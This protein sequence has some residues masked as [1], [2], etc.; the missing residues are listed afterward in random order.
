MISLSYHAL[1]AEDIL[2]KSR[3]HVNIEGIKLDNQPGTLSDSRLGPRTED[4]TCI[5]CELKANKCC[6]DIIGHILLP[7]PIPWA[8][9]LSTIQQQIGGAKLN[10]NT[11]LWEGTGKTA[12]TSKEVAHL[13]SQQGFF[14]TVLPVIK[15]TIRPYQYV[16]GAYRAH[17]MTCQYNEILRIITRTSMTSPTYFSDLYH[18][19]NG[20][21]KTKNKNKNNQE[22]RGGRGKGYEVTYEGVF[23]T[24]G[25]KTGEFR[26]RLHGKRVDFTG[27]SVITSAGSM[28][29]LDQVGIPVIMAEKLTVPDR[30]TAF[31]IDFLSELIR[32]RKVNF[33][34]SQGSGKFRVMESNTEKLVNRLKLGDIVHR[35]LK[36]G[37][38]VV[39][40]RQPTLHK[41]S[42]L[43]FDVEIVTGKAIQMCVDTTPPFNADFDGDCMWILV[44]QSLEARADS[45]EV[46]HVRQNLFDA[47]GVAQFGLVQ[48]GLWVAF[49]LSQPTVYVTREEYFDGFTWCST[50]DRRTLE[51]KLKYTGLEYLSLAFPV[52]FCFLQDD[53]EIQNGQWLKGLAT[54]KILGVGGSLTTVL[55][56]RPDGLRILQLF[57]Q[58]TSEWEKKHDFSLGLSDCVNLPV[59]GE[60]DLNDIMTQTN[61][62]LKHSHHRNR[63]YEMA[64]SGA[65]SKVKDI[66]N[67]T[68]RISAP[69]V[70]SKPLPYYFPDKRRFPIQNGG[71]DEIMT[72]MVHGLPL[73]DMF[74]LACKARYDVSARALLTSKTGYISRKL[75]NLLITSC[76]VGDGI[77]QDEANRVLS[78]TYPETRAFIGESVGLV[79]ASAI[80][81]PLT[82]SVLDTF[83]CSGED[84]S[85][86]DE[87]SLLSL[88]RRTSA[89]RWVV[90]TQ[91]DVVASWEYLAELDTRPSYVYRFQRLFPLVAIT[92][93]GPVLRLRFSK[94]LPHRDFSSMFNWLLKNDL[95]EF[96]L[97]DDEYDTCYEL[98]LRSEFPLNLFVKASPS[99]ILSGRRLNES[100]VEI[101]G[102]TLHDLI[103]IFDLERVSGI[104]MDDVWVVFHSLG[105]EATRQ[106]LLQKFTKAFPSVSSCHLHLLIDH[107]T[108]QGLPTNS[109]YQG[110]SRNATSTMGLACFERAQDV[111]VK[112]AI[113]EEDENPQHP[114]FQLIS[115]QTVKRG[116]QYVPLPEDDDPYFP[117]EF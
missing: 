113:R 46:M 23:A 98:Q 25:S 41:G 16:K 36:T 1:K 5:Y 101:V 68:T 83:H 79:A 13:L 39:F 52:N 66:V 31:N 2:R 3:V 10:L 110:I 69:Q 24:L 112:A 43:A 32:K 73:A 114:L 8:H 48:H 37:D 28:L 96:C 74:A 6:C 26:E 34:E 65:K 21:A 99:T 7:I 82:Q 12:K 19:V 108:Y 53:V 9:Y 117:A 92:K 77:V 15:T 17:P 20:L 116:S 55:L 90:P 42:I 70:A 104:K 85:D 86:G 71:G 80:A 56:K 62:F 97:S 94:T 115:G 67:I 103:H 87:R 63:I 35:H 51:I 4:E 47:N 89:L 61:E 95:T 75:N 54:Q 57:R 58:L 18:A 22:Q 102:G 45:L 50:N 29:R 27:R 100:E 78:F 40:G 11:G 38:V 107:M 109:N 88:S 14:V 49:H 64:Q 72:G 105:I 93:G 59:G 91:K 106:Y 44:P 60:G 111:L 84:K 30:V 81:A 76:Y 33:V